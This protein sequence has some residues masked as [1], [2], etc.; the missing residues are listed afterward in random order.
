MHG[1]APSSTH[2]SPSGYNALIN[3]T[4]H[5]E[6]VAQLNLESFTGSDSHQLN[7]ALVEG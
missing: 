5:I 1:A 3:W 7:R 6:T 2:P 4:F